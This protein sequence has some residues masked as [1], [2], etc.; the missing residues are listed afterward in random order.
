MSLGLTDA[1]LTLMR[2]V[3]RRHPEVTE[4]RIFGSRALGRWQ[5]NS[6]VDVVLWGEIS[7]SALA[8]IAGEFDE[9]PLP[10]LF[11][12]QV[13]SAIGHRPLREHIDRVAQLFYQRAT[14][15]GIAP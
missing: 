13:Y 9:L 8:R 12:L 3:L 1:E 14:P 10:Y 2:E 6:D 11:D 4:A 7:L 5:P 15:A